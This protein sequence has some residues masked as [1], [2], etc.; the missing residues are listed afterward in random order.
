MNKIYLVR[1]GENTANLTKEFSCLKIDYSLTEKGIL[2]A[3][4]TAEF[5]SDKDIYEIY[6]SPLKRAAETAQIIGERLGLG[7][8]VM[9]NFREVNV[10]S[11]EGEPP[12]VENWRYYARII[13]D[14]D[15]GA[16][17]TCF[18]DG[19]NYLTLSARV[20]EGIK[21]V[22][23]GKDGKRIV[24][25]AHGGIFAAAARELCHTSNGSGDIR[26]QIRGEIGNCAVCEIDMQVVNGELRGTLHR[27]ADWSHL[28]GEAA[29][30]VAAMPE[31]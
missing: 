10:G 25:V 8:T 26:S 5:F 12:T 19:E 28:Y 13:T 9:E 15:N 24:I 30:M 20:K 21:K 29:G 6:A 23:G 2:Q 4:Q 31:L 22:V 27:W 1:H 14:W 3:E 11:L 17:D 18:P 7:V 16:V